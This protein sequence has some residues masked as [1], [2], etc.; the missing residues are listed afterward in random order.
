MKN[1]ISAVLVLFL[2][3]IGAQAQI[4]RSKQ[5]KPGPAPK[6]T[7]EVP[8]EFELKNGIKVLVVENHKLPRVSY[9]LRIDNSPIVEGNKA[10]VS[11][12]LGA[13]LGNG[14]TSIS[15]D[16][17]NEEIDFLGARIGFSS[18]SAFGSSL[19]KYSER[20]LELMADA[21]INPLLTEEEFEKE[22]TKLLEGLKNDAKS[23]DA[24]AGRV[25][26]ALSYGKN[27]AY[28]E[29]MTEETINNITFDDVM[30]FYA[31]YFNPNNAYI[32]V[33]GDIEFK[34]AK[35]QIKK[36][37]NDWEKSIEISRTVQQPNAN[38]QYTQINFVDMPNAV[39]SN[40]T[41]TNNVDLQMKDEDYLAAKIANYI[42][43]GGGE[44]Y[45]F[46]NLRE[47]HAYTYGAYSSVG[48]SR[49]NAARFSASASVRNMVTD[50]SIV[51]ILKEITRINTELVDAEA[52][53]SAKAKYVGSF[54][55]ALEQPQTI[56]E[57]A[58]N[59]KLNDLPEDFY[60]T[61]LQKLNALT[62]EDIQNAA[63]K[64]FSTDNAR[65]IVVGKGSEVLG[66]LE[67]SGI[68]IKYY[69]RFANAVEKPVFSKPIPA[70]VTAT[71]VVNNYIKA[72]GGKA[73]LEN[74]KTMFT[75][76][77]VTIEGMPF[78]PTAVIK[79][80][81]PNK[82]S[83]EMNIEGMGTV[84][85]QKFNGT[86]GYAEQQG[87]KIPMSETEV[88]LKQAEKGL[89]PELHFDAATSTLESIATIDGTDV[90]KVKAT[91]GDNVTYKY[92][93]V[94]TSYLVRTETSVKAGEQTITT[95]IDL[96][97]YKAVNGVF[98]P[99]TQKI[100][101]GP[102]VILLSTVDTKFNEGVSDADFN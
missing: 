52:L 94:E 1:K 64:Y 25:G 32:V 30:A 95:T 67:K 102:Q 39:Q 84:M 88:A 65:V 44:G 66:N 27:H 9:S 60:T 87:R 51:E 17:F 61:Y 89:F 90:Y 68:P 78:K 79:A 45:L 40:V 48:S 92:Y 3:A 56:A 31:K 2:M 53:K 5:P 41:V 15:K 80:M 98:V 13:M 74:I 26:G 77:N 63:K 70:G 43:G 59:I 37:F 20:I 73:N 35:K 10:G 7:L 4:D 12:I 71:T 29:F 23:V 49:Y 54:V 83:M 55:M 96:S 97:D 33:V 19:A 18:Q 42:L 6:I 86:A 36:Y 8:G 22:K 76:A 100:T 81:A 47:E 46:K 58:L 14:T 24:V 11:S 34:K 38:V 99:Y 57:Y 16:D 50:S 21:A 62:V 72:I 28:G 75:N 91:T 101:T 69:D 82:S 93:S 85:K